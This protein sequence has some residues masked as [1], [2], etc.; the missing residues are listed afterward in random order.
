MRDAFAKCIID[1]LPERDILKLKD[2]ES[3]ALKCGQAIAF[4]MSWWI[5][6]IIN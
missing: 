2:P 1:E 5:A 6:M 3:A 4:R